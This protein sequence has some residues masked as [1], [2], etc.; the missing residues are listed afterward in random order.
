MPTVPSYGNQRVTESGPENIRLSPA[1]PLEAFGGGQAAQGVDLSGVQRVAVDLWERERKKANQVVNLK[2]ASQLQETATALQVKALSR[3]GEDAFGA[4]D[5]LHEEWGKA[6]EEIRKGLSNDDQRMVFEARVAEHWGQLDG[7]VQ[8]HVA[9]ERVKF[10]DTTTE[11]FIANTTDAAVTNYADPAAVAQSVAKIGA[12]RRDWGRRNG[13]PAE[14]VARRVADDTSK[15]H[16][17]VLARMLDNGQDLTAKAYYDANKAALTGADAASAEK[18]LEAGNLLGESQRQADAILSTPGIA[19][20]QAY[21]KAREIDDPKVRQETERRL[22]V[23]FNRREQSQRD[24]YE[25]TLDQAYRHV[26]E[27]R[28]PP[29]TLWASLKG[30]DRLAI[31]AVLTKEAKGEKVE[32]DWPTYYYLLNN[33]KTPGKAQQAFLGASLLSYRD[34]LGDTEFKE[35]VKIQA[36]LRGGK[37]SPELRGY[38][39][40]A[41]VVDGALRAVGLN[42]GETKDKG[43]IE[44]VANFRRA[45]DDAI[46]AQKRASGKA[47]LSTDDTRKIIDDLLIKTVTVDRAWF[48]G[49]SLAAPGL[50]T[51]DERRR[52]YVP[53]DSIPA[54]D[55]R[56]IEDA[57]RQRGRKVKPEGVARAYGALLAGD[58]VGFNAALG[59]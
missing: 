58:Q 11:A 36:D 47:E 16:A 17:G 18:A 48:V 45:V 9:G 21:E 1:A 19:S 31:N 30:R 25:Q 56:K 26:A 32:T 6:V 41:N 4:P 33:A 20:A 49:D 38:L 15:A 28:R 35:I 59:D 39:T 29:A 37:D 10:D 54:A 22:D 51:A 43:R 24:V 27:G 44:R 8:R 14:E 3:Q 2:V 34:K 40:T 12:A 52:S 7:Q 57:M 42:P 5:E 46:I 13:V 50:M 55:R 53:I 23:E